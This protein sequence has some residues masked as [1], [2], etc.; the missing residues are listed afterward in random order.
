MKCVAGGLLCR[1]VLVSKQGRKRNLT[2]G[3][4]SPSRVAQFG[5]TFFFGCEVYEL[6]L[7]EYR[8]V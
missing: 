1:V 4:P 6:N 7:C 5:D 2:K 8:S 3:T